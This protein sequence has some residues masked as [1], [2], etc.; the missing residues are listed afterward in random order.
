M[1]YLLVLT[2]TNPVSGLPYTGLTPV[3]TAFFN[4]STQQSAP[5]PVISPRPT[6]AGYGTLIS[7][8]S[9]GMVAFGGTPTANPAYAFVPAPN[10]TTFGLFDT[11]GAPLSGQVPSLMWVSAEDTATGLAIN[12]TIVELGG[13]CYVV[14][15]WQPTWIGTL[16]SPNSST[17][18]QPALLTFELP[19]PGSISPPPTPVPVPVP[20][21]AIGTAS[22]PTSG[23]YGIDI[24]TFVNTP[25]G[26]DIDPQ[27]SFVSTPSVVMVNYITRVLTTV[28]GSIFYATSVG[29]SLQQLVNSTQTP[30]SLRQINSQI[31]QALLV[32]APIGLASV[33][34]SVTQQGRSLN[35][36]V[37]GVGRGGPFS[38]V[39]MLSPGLPLSLLSFS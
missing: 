5:G 38:Q 15:S 18:S 26:L 6:Y 7:L 3:W 31:Q 23:V 30:Q 16:A 17:T 1:P 14:P 28:A 29:Y 32:L 13:G 21:A 9:C 35:I 27:L 10:Q 4:A 33:N 8:D 39:Y 34:V 24:N 2:T 25:A 19:E 12:P 36:A 22:V 37:T 20:L 11:S